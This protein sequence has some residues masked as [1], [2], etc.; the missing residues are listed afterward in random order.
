M[1]PFTDYRYGFDFRVR[2]AETDAQGV[3]HNSKYLVYFEVG[4]TEYLRAAGLSYTEL[5]GK[6]I[7]FLL[8]V[9]HVEYRKPARFDQVVHLDVALE[10]IKSS[11]FQF[12]YRLTD[13]I[14]SEV[15]AECYT[16]HVAVEMKTM[17]SFRFPDE[18]RRIFSAFEN[19]ELSV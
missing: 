12:R 15:L 2:F 14:S 18:Y 8:V 11:S 7:D 5:M 6:G 10:W 16:V 1:E 9:S 13:S 19:R 17:K 4:R 3:V